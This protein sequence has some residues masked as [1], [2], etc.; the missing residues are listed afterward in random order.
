MINP[1]Q[2]YTPE[3]AERVQATVTTQTRLKVLELFLI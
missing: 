3:E 2:S 1:K